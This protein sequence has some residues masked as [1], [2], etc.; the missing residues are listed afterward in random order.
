MSPLMDQLFEKVQRLPEETQEHLASMLLQELA[1]EE[2]WDA[3]FADHR[4]PDVLS[5][6]AE[7]ALAEH[8]AGR[9]TKLDP[10]Q[11]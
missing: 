10:D 5:R 8:R 6:L 3:L 4:S 11:L 2:R 1:S 9:T 7:Q